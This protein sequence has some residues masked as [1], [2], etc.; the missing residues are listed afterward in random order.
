MVGEYGAE[1]CE[2]IIY[3]TPAWEKVKNLKVCNYEHK[4]I[5]HKRK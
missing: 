2:V 1:D 4:S 5:L 3:D